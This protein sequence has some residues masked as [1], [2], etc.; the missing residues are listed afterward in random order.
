MGR[1]ES[2]VVSVEEQLLKQH[3]M[4]HKPAIELEARYQTEIINHSSG[5]R[6]EEMTEESSRHKRR[7]WL[8]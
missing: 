7:S 6:D 4:R 5:L 1:W 8:L 3:K 2:D